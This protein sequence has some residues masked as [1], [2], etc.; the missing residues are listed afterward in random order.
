MVRLQTEREERER[1][2]KRERE[3]EEVMKQRHNC[4]L[5][6]IFKVR[7]SQLTFNRKIIASVC[8]GY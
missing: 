4:D 5:S 6:S 3:R 7:F 2:R 8:Y 1:E